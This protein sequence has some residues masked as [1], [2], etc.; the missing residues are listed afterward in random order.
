MLGLIGRK[1]G[2]TQVYDKNGS[3]VPVTVIE[4]GPCTV[5]QQKKMEKDGYDSLQLGFEVS[6]PS[7]MQKARKLHCEKKGVPL[8]A[9]LREFRTSKPLQVGSSLTVKNFKEG[10]LVD[11]ISRSKG[12]GFQGVMKRHGKAGGPASHGSGF[13]RRPGSTGMRTS[14]GRVLKNTRMPGHLGDDRVTI[15]NLS[16]AGVREKE[17]VLLVK[18]GIPGSRGSLVVVVNKMKD[19]EDR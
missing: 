11:V 9:N 1:R 7:K 18:G 3:H 14:P 19:F 6:K 15:K 8:F 12:K 4:A 2:M 17:N 13:H 16:I 10:D 5:V